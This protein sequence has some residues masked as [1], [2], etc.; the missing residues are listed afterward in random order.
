MVQQDMMKN[1]E[2]PHNSKAA[3]IA[4]AMGD[5]YEERIK[6]LLADGMEM[7]KLL[8]ADNPG[9]E[10]FNQEKNLVF[11]AIKTIVGLENFTISNNIGSVNIPATVKN[12]AELTGFNARRVRE[13]II[14][15]EE[16]GLVI[17]NHGSP[18]T[19]SIS[20]KARRFL[21]GD[22]GDL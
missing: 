4:Q 15:L 20:E 19:F 14:S 2:I 5:A 16:D 9:R 21:A 18:A 17:V 8:E 10:F 6:I 3:I 22:D 7:Q 1:P 12:V 13:Q 11:E